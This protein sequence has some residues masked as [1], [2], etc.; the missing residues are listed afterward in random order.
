MA[1]ATEQRLTRIEQ[2]LDK[3]SETLSQLARIAAGKTSRPNR[4]RCTGYRYS[5]GKDDRQGAFDRKSWLDRVCGSGFSRFGQ[6]VVSYQ[7]RFWVPELQ[8]L[9]SWDDHQKFYFGAEK[10]KPP[11]GGYDSSHRES[12]KWKRL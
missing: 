9:L 2:K 4:G 7:G 5:I 3:V 6:S 8:R 11:S 10:Q 1:E 12:I